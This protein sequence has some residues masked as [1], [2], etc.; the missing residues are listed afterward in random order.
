MSDPFDRSDEDLRAV[1]DTVD[2]LGLQPFDPNAPRGLSGVGEA[3]KGLMRPS[4]SAG[5]SL[6]MLGA[7]IAGAM[8]EI[9]NTNPDRAKRGESPTAYQDAYFDAVD[10]VGN[11]AVDFWTPDVAAMGATAKTLNTVNSVIGSIPQMFGT[12]GLFLG[13]A[14]LD[15]STDLV[16]QG[17]DANTATAVGG[18]NLA[19]NAL[20]MKLPAAFGAKLATRLSTG[21]GTNL[22]TG[23]AADAAS[24]GLLSSGGYD[25]QAAGYDVSDPFARGMDLLMGLAFGAKAHVEAP[26]LLPEQR[27]AVLAAANADH[28]TRQTMPGVPASPGADVRHQLALS[29]SIEQLLRGERVD[30]A[31]SIRPE[32]FVLRPEVGAH[33]G[34]YAAYRRALESGGRADA[35]N[36][37]SS[38]LGADQF[39]AATWRRMVAKAKPA[40]A[41]GLSDADLLAARTDSAKS[42]EMAAALDVENRAALEAAGLPVDRHTLY[43]AHHFGA[44]GAKK[45]ARAG[46]DVPMERILTPEQ[47]DANPYLRG[48]TKAEA[49]ANWDD[50]A[51]RA[52]VEFNRVEAPTEDLARAPQEPTPLLDDGYARAPID[53]GDAETRASFDPFGESQAPRARFGGL[54]P[55]MQGGRAPLPEAKP[56]RGLRALF[57]R[58]DP[59]RAPQDASPLPGEPVRAPV[60]PLD[61]ARIVLQSAPDLRIPTGEVDAEG[62]AIAV[63]AADLLTQTEHHARRAHLDAEAIEVA[64]N[65]FLRAGI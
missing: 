33:D 4:A 30:V 31:A 57:G 32:D 49:I 6:M 56:A 27:D 48:K 14:A 8:D 13:N 20:G 15:P 9:A 12:P 47:L 53:G 29:Q 45:F 62:N 60:G 10:D 41:Q 44:A 43:A 25:D 54:D 36:P 16:R 51:R 22:A 64:A 58:R 65:C 52:G 28:F 55:D 7:P 5:R 39:T 17:V 2:E 61:A 35:A 18:V 59:A 11:S 3:M 19:V 1:L 42:G 37:R 26:R 46:D 21:A 23:V 38:A 40:W 50:R 24:H 34:T 63:P